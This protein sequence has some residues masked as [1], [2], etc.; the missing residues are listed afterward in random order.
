MAIKPHSLLLEY[1]PTPEISI[2]IFQRP[3]VLN[4][5][6]YPFRKKIE[7]ILPSQVVRKN[8]KLQ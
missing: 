7:L 8:S 6:L 2:E 1:I 3:F 4:L 5:R